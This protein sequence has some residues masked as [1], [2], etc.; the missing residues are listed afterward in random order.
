MS[1]EK[2]LDQT[3]NKQETAL[4]NDLATE[5]DQRLSPN[6]TDNLTIAILKST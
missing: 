2:K 5:L 3:N 4:K 1:E 6:R